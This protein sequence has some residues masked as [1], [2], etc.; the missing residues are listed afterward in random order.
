MAVIVGILA[1]R[2]TPLFN[3]SQKSIDEA[4]SVMRENILGARVVK[5]FN[6]QEDQTRRYNFFNEK[7][8]FFA[9]RSQ[10]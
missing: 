1:T 5:S 6:L 4:S 2:A 9:Y 8:R 10:S 3:A 7:L